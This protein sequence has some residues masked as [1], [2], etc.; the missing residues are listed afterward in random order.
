M[1]QEKSAHVAT[2]YKLLAFEYFFSLQLRP[3]VDVISWTMSPGNVLLKLWMFVGVG[4]GYQPPGIVRNKR[5]E[6][7]T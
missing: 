7:I 3:C 4:T 6:K 1:R 2:L 5:K